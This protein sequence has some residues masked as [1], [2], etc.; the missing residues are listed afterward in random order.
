MKRFVSFLLLAL[1]LSTALTVAANQNVAYSTYTYT[2]EGDPIKSPH[3]YV[4]GEIL[5]TA[6]NEKGAMLEPEDLFVDT[7]GNIYVADTGNNRILIFNH[8]HQLSNTIDSFEFE[9]KQETF[10]KPGGVFI[11]TTGDIYVADTNNK[12]IVEFS[13]DLKCKRIIAAPKSTLLPSD[14]SFIPSKIVLDKAGRIYVVSK[15]NIYGIIALGNDGSFETF[16]GAQKVIPNISER[17]W[18]MFMT[19]AQIQRTENIVPSNY[20]NISIDELGFLYVTSASSDIHAVIQS[21]M[22]RSTDNR[23]SPVKKLNPKGEDVL[24]RTG[25]FPPAGDVKIQIAPR[26]ALAAAEV[27]YGP[28]FISDVSVGEN[29]VYSLMDQK[30]GKIFTYDVD[31]NLLYAFGGTGYQP[32]LFRKLTSI[33]YGENHLYALDSVSGTITTFDITSYGSL[34]QEAIKLTEERKYE[35]VISVFEDILRENNSFDLANIGIGN[36]MMRQEKYSDAMKYYKSANDLKNYS[37]AFGLNR[38]DIMGNYIMLI[39]VVAALLAFAI[40]QFFK[41]VKNFNAAVTHSPIKVRTV[42]QEFLYEFHVLFHPFDGFWDLKRENRGGF[43]GATIIQVIAVS[44][45]LFQQMSTGYV[46]TG[47]LTNTFNPVLGIITFMGI[48]VLWCTA[49]W[50]LT[51]LMS[52]EGSY[53]DI[54]IATCYSLM[55]IALFTIPATI[56]SNFVTQQE[57]MFVSFLTTIGFIWTGLLLFSAVM[58]IHGYSLGKNVLTIIFTLVGMVLIAFVLLLFVNLIGRMGS[59]IE[60]VYNEITFR[61]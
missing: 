32:G 8:N 35:S 18:R 9:G 58:T 40:S 36:A 28:S 52:G 6:N 31:G 12:R 51:S 3:A 37:K 25:F 43:R 47:K 34:V 59:F 21:I 60:N 19:K 1:L 33:A 24:L 29:G 5:S 14:F 13:S 2:Y 23:Y 46:A 27:N 41:Y 30:R 39:P 7:N 4:P 61:M 57:L 26:G 45:L 55:P 20:N 10:L 22:S 15:G 11:T 49:N 53:K 17:F 54:Y 50:C 42:K 38:K 48:L 56:L 16:I 44:S